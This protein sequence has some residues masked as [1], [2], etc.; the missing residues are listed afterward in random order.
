MRVSA[1]DECDIAVF[2]FEW[3]QN[4]GVSVAVR[5]VP[6]SKLVFNASLRGAGAAAT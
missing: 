4:A 5:R 2:Q 6:E 3:T 1:A